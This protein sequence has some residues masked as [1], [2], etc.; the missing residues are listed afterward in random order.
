M[1]I[2]TR[3]ALAAALS[4]FAA[5]AAAAPA[6]QANVLSLL[7]G[8]CS[9]ESEGQVFAQFGDSNQYTLVP[10]GNFEAGT[11]PW[12]NSGGA[13]RADGNESY[14]V[15]EADD[16]TSLSLPDGSATVS[17]PVCANI[18]KPT[19]RF[20]ARNTGSSSSRLNVDVYYPGLL[21]AVRSA[22]LGTV[23]AGPNWGPTDERQLTVTNLL[24]TLSL[25]RTVI[26]F[27]F[28]PAD[29]NGEWSIDDVY[30]DPKM[31]G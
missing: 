27:R 25:S 18:Y 24:A 19:L 5:A 31:R 4:C 17:P 12:L 14:N 8:S 28:S 29:N 3:T 6:A 15:G 11:I 20:F 13:A 22:R 9:G 30:V 23:S 2:R 21:G 1:R 26:A 7:P 10:G 16:S